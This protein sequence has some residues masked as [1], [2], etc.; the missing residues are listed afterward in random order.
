MRTTMMAS[1]ALG[2]ALV[3][4]GC[5]RHHQAK[6]AQFEQRIADRCVTAARSAQP[7]VVVVPQG[8][9]VTTPAP[10]TTIVIPQQ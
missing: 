8:A 6:M 3:T 9:A 10:A 4:T 2:A 7:Q 1:L 5:G